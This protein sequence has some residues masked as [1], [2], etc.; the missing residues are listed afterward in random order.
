MCD[1]RIISDNELFI[2]AIKSLLKECVYFQAKKCA[3]TLII[4]DGTTLLSSGYQYN[5]PICGMIVFIDSPGHEN[6]IRYVN[7]PFK[8]YCINNKS[9]MDYVKAVL[10]DACFSIS[11]M[12]HCLAHINSP[13]DEWLT[14]KEFSIISD[15]FRGMCDQYVSVKYNVT[16]KTAQNYRKGALNKLR[17]KSNY[18]I[19][20]KIHFF[21]DFI[22]V[23]TTY[24]HYLAK[25]VIKAE[26]PASLNYRQQP[27]IFYS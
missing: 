6:L 18:N 23:I 9:S 19:D 22:E 12:R 8:V 1:I 20:N 5:H 7:S 21:F 26:C 16:Y 14:P 4:S 24:Q 13:P 11:K 3:A 27:V 17:L 15:V 25:K 10:V 2:L